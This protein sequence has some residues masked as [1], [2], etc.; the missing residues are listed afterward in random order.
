MKP[1][2]VCINIKIHESVQPKEISP[3]IVAQRK[4]FIKFALFLWNVERS[5]VKDTEFIWNSIEVS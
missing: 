3:E 2:T 4:E 1:K 5:I